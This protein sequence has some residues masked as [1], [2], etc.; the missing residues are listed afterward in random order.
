MWQIHQS[1]TRSSKCHRGKN[2]YG[3]CIW[4]QLC[5]VFAVQHWENVPAF[6]FSYLLCKQLHQMRSVVS[7]IYILSDKNWKNISLNK[8]IH[9]I[10][11][12]KYFSQLFTSGRHVIQTSLQVKQGG[13]KTRQTWLV[14]RSKAVI[15]DPSFHCPCACI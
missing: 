6:S 4:Y 9:E 12:Y 1:E 10:L 13:N 3:P 11:V 8:V 7:Q 5:H 14:Q 2:K 15:T